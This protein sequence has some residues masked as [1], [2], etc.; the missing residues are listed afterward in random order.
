M[1][2]W[3]MDRKLHLGSSAFQGRWW[4][5]WGPQHPTLGQSWQARKSPSI[6]QSGLPH[7]LWNSGIRRA[8]CMAGESRW[9]PHLQLGWN[10]QE[11]CQY[12]SQQHSGQSDQCQPGGTPLASTDWEYHILALLPMAKI[13]RNCLYNACRVVAVNRKTY[14]NECQDA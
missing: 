9:R 7:N 4:S 6:A 2:H 5:F 14:S 11:Y 3:S 10:F 1:N 8:H 12:C 13:K